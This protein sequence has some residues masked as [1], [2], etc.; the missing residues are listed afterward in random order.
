MRNEGRGLIERPSI[1]PA[2][3]RRIA[4]FW[5]NAH[6]KEKVQV[7]CFRFYWFGFLVFMATTLSLLG[8]NSSKEPVSSILDKPT[9]GSP[10]LGK[11]NVNSKTSKL[12]ARF[13]NIPLKTQ[14]GKSVRFY[15]DL[16]KDHIVIINFMY[17]TCSD[18]VCLPTTAKL[19]RVHKLLGGR[20]GR[21]IRILSVTIDPEV[22]TPNAL[23]EYS[24]R[25][26]DKRGWFYLTGDYDD[27]DRLR[28]KLGVYDLDPVIDADKSQHS[29]L[30]QR[31]FQTFHSKHKTA[32]R[33]VFTMTW[34]RI[35][36]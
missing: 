33:C 10:E 3:K 25:F 30:C 8:C 35:T 2:F 12:S 16:V 21:D 15:D 5:S 32:N 23:K 18:G 9:V 7:N 14:D 26:G 4:L 17:T 31:G 1:G 22:D 34:L 29:G 27:I 11:S 24:N 20:V 6:K 28:H 36:S 19:A 13:P